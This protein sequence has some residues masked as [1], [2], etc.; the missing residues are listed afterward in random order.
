MAGRDSTRLAIPLFSAA[1]G[2]ALKGYDVLNRRHTLSGL[3]VGSMKAL[4][5]GMLLGVV[6]LITHFITTMQGIW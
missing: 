5:A 1:C 2:M 6:W 4:V 3:E